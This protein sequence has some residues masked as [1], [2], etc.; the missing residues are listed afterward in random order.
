IERAEKINFRHADV[1]FYSFIYMNVE[2]FRINFQ[3]VKTL[4]WLVLNCRPESRYWKIVSF[5]VSLD[6]YAIP[7]ARFTPL[8][9]IF[10]KSL[11]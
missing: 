1:M 3:K 8:T 4:F 6:S 7:L 11:P 5:L 2:F 10:H 9:S